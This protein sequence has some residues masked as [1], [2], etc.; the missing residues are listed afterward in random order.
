VIPKDGVRQKLYYRAG[1]IKIDLV[2]GR[3]G[4]DAHEPI[5]FDTAG[6]QI[7]FTLENRSGD[8]HILP[9]QVNGL[10]GTYTV[11]TNGHYSA[12]V[13]LNGQ[14]TISIPVPAGKGISVSV[15]KTGN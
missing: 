2:L 4:F 6:K 13:V 1:A 9:V 7:R 11:K 5:V 15:V 8:A 14:Q 10:K 3:D 12:T